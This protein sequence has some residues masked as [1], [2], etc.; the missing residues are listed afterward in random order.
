[1]QATFRAIRV[2][3]GISI[4]DAAK[5]IGIPTSRLRAIERHK[6]VPSWP[7][8]R[9]MMSVYDIP[10]IDNLLVSNRKDEINMHYKFSHDAIVKCSCKEVNE[11]CSK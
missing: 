7:L 6:T 2:H 9:R 10:S 8:I 1:M 4:D 5:R 3:L 11:V